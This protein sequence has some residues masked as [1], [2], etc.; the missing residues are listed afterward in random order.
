MTK[1]RV[2][3]RFAETVPVGCVLIDLP[4]SYTTRM[5]CEGWLFLLTCASK[6]SWKRCLPNSVVNWEPWD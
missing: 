5:T 4:N 3:V 2:K 1:I 6:S